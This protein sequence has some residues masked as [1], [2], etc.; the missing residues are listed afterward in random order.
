MIAYGALNAGR[1]YAALFIRVFD[2][3]PCVLSEINGDETVTFAYERYRVAFRN[4][5][6]GQDYSFVRFNATQ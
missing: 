1:W 6:S 2:V 5:L 4:V 3:S